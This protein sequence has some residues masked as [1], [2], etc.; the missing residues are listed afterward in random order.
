MKQTSVVV[1]TLAAMAGVSLLLLGCVHSAPKFTACIFL[2]LVTIFLFMLSEHWFTHNAGEFENRFWTLM[3]FCFASACLFCRDSPLRFSEDRQGIAWCVVCLFAYLC[4]IYDRDVRRMFLTKQVNMR[5]QRSA[6][7]NVQ[8]RAQAK[9]KIAELKKYVRGIDQRWMSSA[10]QNIFFLPYVLHAES[11]IYNILQDANADELNLILGDDHFELAL[12]LYKVKDHWVTKRY[13]RSKI[14]DLLAKERVRELNVRSRAVLLDAIQRLKLSAHVKLEEYVKNIFYNTKTDDL[15]DLKCMTD[16]KADINSMHHL[17]FVDI[18]SLEIKQSILDHIGR[19]ARIQAAHNVMGGNISRRRKRF[20]WRKI[21]SDVDDTL[22]CCGGSWPAGMDASYPKKSIYPGVIAFYREL[23]LGTSGPDQ[24]DTIRPGNLVFLS[25][26]PHVYK[27]VS[28]SATY[29][30]LRLLQEKRG[31]HTSPTLLAGDLD[32]GGK[33]L[34]SKDSEPLAQKKYDNFREFLSLYPEFTCIFIGDNGQ[35]DVRAAE[36]VMNNKDIASNLQRS[37]IHVIQPL[38]KM[39]VASSNMQTYAHPHVCYFNSYIDA[40]LDAYKNQLIRVTGLQRIMIEAV[41]D[42]FVISEADWKLI[43]PEVVRS[44]TYIP[45][46]VATLS[47][48]ASVSQLSSAN[49]RKPRGDSFSTVFGFSRPSSNTYPGV[50]TASQTAQQMQ[51]AAKI[52]AASIDA[53]DRSNIGS[54]PTLILSPPST[55]VNAPADNAQQQVPPPFPGLPPPVIGYAAPT[56]ERITAVGNSVT[57]TVTKGVAGLTPLFAAAGESSRQLVK[58]PPLLSASAKGK[59]LSF[60][61][62]NRQI[63]APVVIVGFSL[64]DSWEIHRNRAAIYRGP[65]SGT[66]RVSG[67]MKREL[68]IRELNNAIE[69]GNEVLIKNKLPP[70]E[71]I[72]FPCVHSIGRLVKTPFGIASVTVFRETDGMYELTI[73]ADEYGQVI[74]ATPASGTEKAAAVAET[75]VGTIRMRLYV[76]GMHL[77]D[78]R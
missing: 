1:V 55:A 33:F 47:N 71:K 32:T 10:L 45:N 44:V 54:P 21:I 28:E 77:D 68:R 60:F 31:L 64:L 42:F 4:H 29:T 19:E 76:A 8:H 18:R 20:A 72:S 14:L 30:K 5:K 69:A 58:A 52:A 7:F 75:E 70:V 74:V 57:A 49:E 50:L 38:S 39:H 11:Q 62:S 13:N 2:L 40:A 12:I 56:P 53:I 43:N 78:L 17:L 3:A 25:A 48:S 63:A 15:S 73:R 61:P 6:D 26:R 35:G 66:K 59:S 22:T 24:L 36:M 67:L 41:R 37:Y 65:R 27:D 46:T 51:T 9:L 23:D 34:I 16:A